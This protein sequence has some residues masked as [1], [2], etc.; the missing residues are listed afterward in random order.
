MLEWLGSKIA[1]T[2]L[3]SLLQPLV[4]G[5]LTYQKQ[6]LDAAG[7]QEARVAELAQRE[8]ALDQRD[9]E[10]QAQIV[11]A[12]QGN[13]FTRSVRP[14][15]GWIVIILLA[16]VLLYDKAFGQWT[17]G[18]TDGL[19]AHLWSV[20]QTVLIAYFGARSAEKVADKIAGVFA[21]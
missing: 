14:T 11:I 9:A 7:S 21:K 1:G 19:D 13:W 10:V 8:I 17:G 20:V 18:H 5:A 2:L 3:G 4:N 6:K 16:K 12:E 15:V